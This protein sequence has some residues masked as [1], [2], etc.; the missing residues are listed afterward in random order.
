[1]NN[2]LKDIQFALRTLRKSP[3]F[4]GI[5]VLSLAFGI[6]ANTAIFTLLDQVILRLLPVK[7]PEQLVLIY[8]RGGHYGN[9]R[10]GAALSYPMYLDFKTRNTLFSDLMCRYTTPMS[11]TV[12]NT[13]ERVPGELVSGNYFQVLGVGAARGR[14][15]TPEDDKTP[16][17]HPIAMLS[18]GFWRTRF[19]GDPNIIGKQVKL[20]GL[21]MTIIGVSPQGFDG[22]DP[23]LSPSIRVPMMMKAQMTPGWDDMKNRRSRW[24]NVFGRLKPGATIEKAK[25]EMQ[26]IFHQILEMEVKEKDFANATPYTRSQF[27]KSYI[28]MDPAGNGRSSLRQQFAK[29]LWVL[30]AVVGFVLLIACANV[31]NLLIARASGRQKEIAIRLALGSSRGRLIQQLLVESTLLS[32]AGGIL[33]LVFSLI[34]VKLLLNFL[35]MDFF[36]LTLSST[37]DF[38]VLGFTF[39]ISILTGLLF[40]LAPA[41]QT[42]RPDIAPTLKDQAGNVMGGG[43]QVYFRK[44]LVIAQV[45]LSLL[46]LIGAGL[47]IQSLRN[48]KTLNPGFKTTN[49]IAFNLDP[50]LNYQPERSRQV[51]KNL[52]GTMNTT[53]GVQKAGLAGVR[54]LE[55]NEWDSSISVEGYTAKPGE[56]MQAFMNSVSPGYFAALGIPLLEGRDFRESDTIP[57]SVKENSPTVAVVNQSF[58]KHYFGNQSAIG[59]HVGFGG[60]PGTKLNIEI[61]GVIGDAKYMSM[62]DEIPRQMF[63]TY[64]QDNQPGGM[65]M[66]VR[67]TLPS[68]QM[69]NTIRK[70]M[71]SI[72]ASVPLFNMK[73]IESQLDDNLVKERL[74]ASLSSFFGALATLL[75][76][77]GLYGVMAYTV[78]QRTREIGIR[79]A[80]GAIRGDVLWLVMKE[81]LVLVVIGVILGVP[82]ALGLAR[83]VQSQLYGLTPADPIT[84]SIA[85]LVLA[86]VACLAGYIPALRATRID[87]MTA[88]RYE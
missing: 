13:T 19:A 86:T 22:T 8:S 80:L 57:T 81:V 6:G 46:L 1:M 48:L 73:T 78:T 63:V 84:V 28:V 33:G 34:T 54:I 17:G 82:A 77:I 32:V 12:G 43:S 79:M 53:P 56:D 15:F 5:A 7:D 42:T 11:M 16:G 41:L 31:A 4:T 69:F 85:T 45:T 18:Y 25:A 40:G 3:V 44:A 75:A 76:I 65:T 70:Q 49:L 72:D 29:P 26:T 47:F 37:P 10:G 30:M 14:T 61:V 58:A 67:T 2:L 66:F 71:Q 39:G 55:D 36:Q 27:L 68:E 24:I 23:G 83:L 59:K 64:L 9:N 62:R 35:P 38:R 60:D 21:S 87:P 74:I 50:T 88:L 51:Y 52:T 20:N